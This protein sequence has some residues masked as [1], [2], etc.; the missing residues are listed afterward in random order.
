[1]SHW[2]G[3]SRF[4]LACRALQ[5]SIRGGCLRLR[6]TPA[7]LFK[8][9]CT[10]TAPNRWHWHHWHT[11]LCG[12]DDGPVALAPADLPLEPR[13][14]TRTCTRADNIHC[15]AT[16]HTQLEGWEC[17]CCVSGALCRLVPRTRPMLAWGELSPVS[18]T[19]VVAVGWSWLML[20][21]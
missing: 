4:P 18:P 8:Q 19:D 7:H 10:V 21:S 16:H 5:H 2:D 13:A 17:L 3:C 11:R 12:H 14:S 20:R 1:M 9:T 6:V 15:T